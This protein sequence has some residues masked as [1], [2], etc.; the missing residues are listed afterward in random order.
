[1]NDQEIPQGMLLEH[2]RKY[3]TDVVL[4]YKPNVI[5]ESGTWYG[6]GST[7]SLVKGLYEN[8]KGILHTVEE[9]SDYYEIANNFYKNSQY[10]KYIKL[11]K[12]NFINMINNF[13]LLEVDLVFLDGGDEK[14]CGNAKLDI[15]EYLENYNVSE[16]VQS[17][18]ILEEKIRPNT[19]IILHDWFYS[20][21]RGN[22]V[23]RYLEKEDK[24][25]N[26]KLEKSFSQYTGMAHLIK[27]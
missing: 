1:M 3:L 4:K 27:L 8:E 15:N 25:K 16:N 20:H 9:H 7:L 12:D 11:Y 18:K 2:E 6:G 26:Y 14:P 19:H 5:L 17:F 24:M 22:F 13:N 21:G 10:S 23:K